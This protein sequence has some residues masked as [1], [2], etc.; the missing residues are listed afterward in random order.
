[1]LK[2]K[3]SCTNF[4]ILLKNKN[5]V[6]ASWWWDRCSVHLTFLFFQNP[7]HKTLF[8]YNITT[9]RFTSISRRIL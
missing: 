3:N 6:P 7:R 2:L 4:V 9:Y 5:R 1:M 8:L